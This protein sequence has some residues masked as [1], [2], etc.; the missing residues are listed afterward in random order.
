MTPMLAIREQP[1]SGIT[2][3]RVVDEISMAP[4]IADLLASERNLPALFI[5]NC[6][7]RINGELVPRDRWTYVRLRP[8]ATQ[9]ISVTFTQPMHGGGGGNTWKLIATI[10]IVVVALIVSAGTFAAALPAG[11]FLG[12]SASAW[13]GAA[14][15]IGGSLALAALTPSPSLDQGVIPG[16]N[17]GI[18]TDDGALAT[19]SAASLGGNVLGK[20][21]S[22][23]RVLG[24]MRLFPPILSPPLIEIVGDHSVAEAVY[25][26]AGPHAISHLR[27]GT[28]P[29]ELLPDVEIEIQEGLLNS[30]IQGLVSR[31]SFTDQS[32]AIQ[33]SNHHIDLSS[34]SAG[35][36]L[37]NQTS[38]VLSCP[39]WEGFT[40][41]V[42][43]DEVWLPVV[44]PG[45]LISTTA[46]AAFVP[47]R[48]RMRQSGATTWINLPEFHAVYKRQNPVQFTIKLMWE[49]WDGIHVTVPDQGGPVRAWYTVPTQTV[50]SPVGAGG[51]Q[52]NS[53]FYLG[54]GDKFLSSTN[55]T[56]T[57]GLINMEC[58]TDR[59]EFYLGG[60]ASPD[61]FPNS[62]IWEVQVMRGWADLNTNI[63]V[64]DSYLYTDA[65]V[66]DPFTYYLDGS[67]IARIYGASS[68]FVDACQIPRLSSIWNEPPVPD[69]TVFATVS[70]KVR[71]RSV[72]EL[73]VEASGYVYDWDGAN[74][75]T[76]TTSSNPATL[77]HEV[78]TGSLGAMPL[79][80]E[81][82]DNASLVTWRT[83][84]VTNSYVCN[85][86]VEGRKYFD[87]SNMIAGTG[88]A[89]L[90]HNEKW[91]VFLDKDR[92]AESPIQIFTPRNMKDFKWTK[93][94]AN[95]PAGIR[96]SFISSALNYQNDEVIVYSDADNPDISN[97]EQITYD[98]LVTTAQITARATFDLGQLEKRMTFYNGTVDMESLVCQRGDLVGVQHDTLSGQ[99]GFGLVK[100]VEFGGGL[101]TGLVMDGT[102]PI[103]QSTGLFVATNI[104][105]KNF[106]DFG[107]DTGVAIRQKNGGTIL[108]KQISTSSSDVETETTQITFTTPFTDPGSSYLAE[109]CLCTTGLLGSEYKRL[110]VHTI[111]PSEDM[112]ASITFVDEAPELWT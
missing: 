30:P 108:I 87:I 45:G 96:A 49:A 37:D 31:Q 101:V 35:L 110:L 111:V 89:R 82:M 20:G 74:W 51:W 77:M 23:P 102:I 8:Q 26:L 27:V 83:H 50:V 54:S 33:L 73:S 95:P 91:G 7:A 52:A 64:A 84:C 11:T 92:S 97:V 38:P 99:A 36:F 88:Y 40:T 55:S 79:P 13:A 58:F 62:G 66:H 24:T 1:F 17:S 69:P 47:F 70:V 16:F 71:D 10:A 32:V 18:N 107:S 105:H 56:T 90:F 86:V 103:V 28:T 29:I 100:T 78:L 53:Y 41:R 61:L 46:V 6:E 104:Y 67:S 68:T 109:G 25:G 12:V 34:A 3:V 60:T 106:F 2:R 22:V 19:S 80:P 42:A 4:S 75:G 57:T 93:V 48:V 15:A 112:T 44:F 43:P 5:E 85:A 98:G 65:A 63:T 21:R 59:V 9:A 76:L 81:V 39:E 72:N 14:I 94:F